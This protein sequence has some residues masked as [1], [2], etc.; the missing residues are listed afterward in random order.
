MLVLVMR[1]I[2]GMLSLERC[3]EQI[4]WGWWWRILG[5]VMDWDTYP[6]KQGL[7]LRMPMNKKMSYGD[8][9]GV[10]GS[11]KKWGSGGREGAERMEDK[12]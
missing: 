8:C 2:E 5:V 4:K 7:G 1:A 11:D 10:N 6:T 9:V 3:S 12:E